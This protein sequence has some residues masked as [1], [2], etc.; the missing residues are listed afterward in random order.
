MASRK[1]CPFCNQIIEQNEQVCPHCGERNKTP[2]TIEELKS[3]CEKRGMPL[4]RMRFFIGENY[5]KP[6]AFGIYEDGGSYI[7]YK[8]K[9]NGERA[10]R[11]SGP[12]EAYAVRELFQKLLDEC[13]IRDINPDGRPADEISRSHIGTADGASPTARRKLKGKTIF[14]IVCAICF[15]AIICLFS[16]FNWTFR[17]YENGY[18]KLNNS[19]YVKKGSHWY[20]GGSSNWYSRNG[21]PSENVVYLGADYDPEW[22]IIEFEQSETGK[23]YQAGQYSNSNNSSYNDY[24]SSDYSSWDS[25]DTDWDSDW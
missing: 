20:Y 15:I 25:G 1:H 3:Y 10:T 6:K 5:E 11:Y 17:S 19:Y 23:N 8:N 4:S 18:Y 7:V 9:A 13:H 12:D 16:T 14:L 2:E 24:S 22:N 21:S